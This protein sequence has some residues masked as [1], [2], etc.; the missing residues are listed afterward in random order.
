M[1]AAYAWESVAV[2]NT[3]IGFTAA[4]ITADIINGN[5]GPKVASISVETAPIRYRIDG[6]DPDAATG[7]LLNPGDTVDII[8]VNDIKRFKAIRTGATSAA[9]KVTYYR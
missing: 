3:A 9:I 6:T 1:A 4:N 2:A 5:H 7:T 8:G